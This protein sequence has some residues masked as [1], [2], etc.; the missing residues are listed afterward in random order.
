MGGVDYAEQVVGVVQVGCT[1]PEFLWSFEPGPACFL[2]AL[3]L[4]LP[5]SPRSIGRPWGPRGD[6]V[7][8]IWTTRYPHALQS[9][10]M[11]MKG[12]GSNDPMAI[13]TQFAQSQC[14]FPAA[15]Q[16]SVQVVSK[17]ED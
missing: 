9:V 4:A 2:S 13:V 15:N 11:L 17:L 6:L 14:Y 5:D 1:R 8:T 16:L 7:V 10:D 12:V 3:L